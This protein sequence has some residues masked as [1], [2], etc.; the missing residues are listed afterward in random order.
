MSAFKKLEKYSRSEM[1]WKIRSLPCWV[2]GLYFHWFCPFYRQERVYKIYA[3]LNVQRKTLAAALSPSICYKIQKW[4]MIVSTQGGTAVTAVE[5]AV[6]VLE[7]DSAFNAGHGSCLTEAG[8]VEMDA[9]ICDGKTVNTGICYLCLY[10][11][12]KITY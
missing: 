10:L 3:N 4:N 12:C 11:R 8:T 9:I 7:D 5:K 2:I 6:A 1:F